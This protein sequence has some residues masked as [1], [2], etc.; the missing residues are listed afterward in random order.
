MHGPQNWVGLVHVSYEN[1][2][3][4]DVEI[5]FPKHGRKEQFIDLLLDQ[6][7][8]DLLTKLSTYRDIIEKPIREDVNVIRFE[9]A[10]VNE[11]IWIPG[12]Q[13]LAN[14]ALKI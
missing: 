14:T 13:N 7:T 9:C 1:L 6:K 8:I 3:H 5:H 10:N 2:R 11:I 12:C 4:L